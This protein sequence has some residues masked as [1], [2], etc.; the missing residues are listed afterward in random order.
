MKLSVD[1]ND[2]ASP[3]LKAF[4]VS[5]KSSSVLAVMA[6]AVKKEVQDHL[7]GRPANKKGYPTTNFYKRAARATNS[8]VDGQR[9]WVSITGPIGIVQRF[10]GGLIK[11]L[12]TKFLTLP[13]RAES[14][15]KR[16]RD[17]NFLEFAMAKNQWGALQPALVETRRTEFKVGRKKKDGTQTVTPT[18]SIIGGGVYFWLTRSVDQDPD[19]NVI[20]KNEDMTREAVQAGESF[21][22][23]EIQRGN[24]S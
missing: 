21:V 1:I 9:A 5:M 16:A 22:V 15:G 2:Q 18:R 7:L 24:L 13:A 4:L 17:F 6:T 11:A 14:Y 3:A 19:P 23:R 12:T 20:P 8:R 10:F